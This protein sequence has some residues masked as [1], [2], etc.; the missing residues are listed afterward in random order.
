MKPSEEENGVAAPVDRIV[1]N[2]M[3]VSQEEKDL[4]RS[5]NER[6][7]F[8][9]SGLISAMFVKG[10]RH[11]VA[12][13]RKRAI[14]AITDQLDCLAIPDPAQVLTKQIEEIQLQIQ[15]HQRGRGEEVHSVQDRGQAARVES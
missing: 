10:F 1:R 2:E 4:I 3:Q 5:V 9:I 8:D 11:G 13:M 7:G 15:E 6:I 14:V 12:T